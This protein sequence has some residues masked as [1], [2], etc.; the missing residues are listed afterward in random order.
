[1][2]QE[3]GAVPIG[4]KVCVDITALL[5]LAEL[6]I[7]DLL[8]MNFGIITIAQQTRQTIWMENHPILGIHPLA[9]KISTWMESNRQK[10]RVRHAG[11]EVHDMG[12]ALEYHSTSAGIMTPTKT[13]PLNVMLPDGAGESLMLAEKLQIPLYSDES[14]IRMWARDNHRVP[15]SVPWV[16]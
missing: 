7:L 8:T 13:I 11:T 3:A 6:D 1:M 9:E 2:Q 16:L 14:C 4:E 5:T 15:S 12:E 10:I